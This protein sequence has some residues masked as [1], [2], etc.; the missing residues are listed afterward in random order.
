MTTESASSVPVETTIPR[1][2]QLIGLVG[3]GVMFRRAGDDPLTIVTDLNLDL[4]GGQLL[5]IAGRSGS[6]KTS[7]LRVAAGLTTPSSGTVRWR[8]T[9]IGPMTADG[10]ARERRVF[11]G[12][13]EQSAPLLDDL[14][15]LENV[16]LPAVPDRR[17][18]ELRG[19]AA[20]LLGSLGLGGRL[21]HRPRALSGG[22]RQRIALARALL[23]QPPVLIADEPTASLDRRWADTVIDTLTA[24]AGSGTAVLVASH[25]RHLIERSTVAST[26]D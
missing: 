26:L 22:E 7:I 15:A 16:L 4:Q 8:G 17:T 9:D 21:T 20:D 11:C 24:A 12:I 23:L 5:C 2:G 10:R 18:R 6:G 13:V 25:D 3:V 14:T 1:F 19:R